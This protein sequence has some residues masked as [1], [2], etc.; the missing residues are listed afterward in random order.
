[1]M[2]QWILNTQYFTFLLRS[3]TN[4]GQQCY[5]D[6]IERKSTQW[7]FYILSEEF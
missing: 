6:T 5:S 7:K 1:M 3:V 4:K 2:T